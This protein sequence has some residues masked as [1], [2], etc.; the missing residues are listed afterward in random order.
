LSR[1]QQDNLTNARP[2]QAVFRLDAALAPGKPG[3]VDRDGYEVLTKAYSPQT[4]QHFCKQIPK[5]H[6]G[7]R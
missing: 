2:M 5:T 6:N 4:T 3:F 1:F 7:S